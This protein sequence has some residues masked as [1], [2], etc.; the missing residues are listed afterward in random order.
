[1]KRSLFQMSIH[2]CLVPCI[3]KQ[4]EKHQDQIWTVH[5]LHS[6]LYKSIHFFCGE[7]NQIF[8]QNYTNKDVPRVGWSFTPAILQLGL[9]WSQHAT[10]SQHWTLSLKPHIQNT[11]LTTQVGNMS[12]TRHQRLQVHVMVFRLCSD[13]NH[14]HFHLCHPKRKQKW[15]I[16]KNVTKLKRNSLIRKSG[17]LHLNENKQSKGTC[18]P[19]KYACYRRLLK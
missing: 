3:S 2:S 17:K 6:K 10:S 15:T 12:C 19:T 7:K 4:L 11:H 16:V 5:G 13:P 1:M 9:V 8:V 18:V 14:R